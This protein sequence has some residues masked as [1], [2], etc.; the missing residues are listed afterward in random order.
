MVDFFC[1]AK[2]KR[3]EFIYIIHFQQNVAELAF[4]GCVGIKDILK[5]FGGDIKNIVFSVIGKV[6]IDVDADD[7]VT[8][9]SDGAYGKV[10]EQSAV[11]ISRSIDLNGRKNNRNGA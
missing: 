3:I 10:H 8:K 4:V 9:W 6:R 7:C 11:Y 5:R 1:T 2:I